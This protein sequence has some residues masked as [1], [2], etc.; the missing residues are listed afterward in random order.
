MTVQNKKRN[1]STVVHKHDFPELTVVRAKAFD[2]TVFF[3]RFYH[4]ITVESV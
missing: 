4:L 3:I 2:S 1:F